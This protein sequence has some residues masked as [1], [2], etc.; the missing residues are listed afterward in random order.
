MLGPAF[1]NKVVVMLSVIDYKQ[2]HPNISHSGNQVN[3]RGINNL[4]DGH[5][6]SH[7]KSKLTRSK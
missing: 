4:F 3:F 1:L 5:S 2:S 7:S 6:Y